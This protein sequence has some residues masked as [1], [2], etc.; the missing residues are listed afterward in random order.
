MRRRAF[1][2]FLIVGGI[3]AYLLAPAAV[4]GFL[5]AVFGLVF[6]LFLPGYL[7]TLVLFRK[8]AGGAPDALKCRKHGSKPDPKEEP[9]AL[10]CRN[11]GG[12]EEEID[13]LERLALAIGLS[14]SLVV[15]T[16]MFSN[17]VLK[18]PINLF[19]SV[20][21]ISAICLFFG[22]IRALQGNAG[23]MRHYSRVE[24]FLMLRHE[25]NPKRRLL[26]HLGTSVL[27][28]LLAIDFGYPLLTTPLATSRPPPT[29]V[30]PH[31]LNLPDFYDQSMT[32]QSFY[33][34]RN[35]QENLT[36]LTI[37]YP[38]VFTFD[39]KIAFLGYDLDKTQ[40]KA[41]NTLHVAYYWKALEK[42]DANYSVL[43]EFTDIND[44][45]KFN[46]NHEFKQVRALP[47]NARIEDFENVSEW[48]IG[49]P[50]I[51]GT[52]FTTAQDQTNIPG[53]PP[54]PGL[55][56]YSGRLSYNFTTSGNDYVEL[57][58][59]I[60]LIGKPTSIGLWVYGDNSGHILRSRFLDANNEMYQPTY[61][62][63]NWTG[64]KYAE[65]RMDNP[66]QGHWG[67]DGNGAIDYPISFYGLVLDDYPETFSGNGTVYFSE[68]RVFGEANESSTPYLGIPPTSGWAKNQIIQ[69]EYD[70]KIPQSNESVYIMKAG[71]YNK[72]A[73]KRAQITGGIPMDNGNRAII[74]VLPV[75][76]EE[77]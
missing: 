40:V 71:L 47:P 22:S 9:D 52:T 12:P 24:D 65:M 42:M 27:L 53:T 55:G 66:T 37:Q 3:A 59:R 57:R 32:V 14:I 36:N 23:F 11:S 25:K 51:N 28:I 75:Q 46:Q 41:G 19:T 29:F 76:G 38:T 43:V 68:L 18:I 2:A 7:A 31:E 8:K 45:V 77:Q 13:A 21:E 44:T 64:W 70:L 4:F 61:G 48:T 10:E 49:G 62:K 63:I 50:G 26:I 20:A 56:N 17:L 54:Q 6:V 34:Q 1:A 67:G 33:P 5:R 58:N 72:P 74:G 30:R 35:M 16:V 39:N 73:G 15:L 69:E 60:L